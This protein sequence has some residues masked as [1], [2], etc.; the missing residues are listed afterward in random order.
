MV[1]ADERTYVLCRTLQFSGIS[2]FHIGSCSSVGRTCVRWVLYISDTALITSQT[3]V[4]HQ[5]L[6]TFSNLGGTWPR[7]FVLTG[8]DY[9]T[10]A[11][12]EVTS[13]L[14]TD[15]KSSKIIV[16]GAQCVSDHRKEGSCRGCGTSE[17]R[18][19]MVVPRGS[20]LYHGCH[21]R[22]RCVPL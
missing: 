2:A 4:C 19:S 18:W 1:W 20:S 12:C 11:T 13:A 21:R 7:Y 8:I 17:R 3:D 5:L 10:V 16:R 22:S 6:N 14:G 15:E 9:F